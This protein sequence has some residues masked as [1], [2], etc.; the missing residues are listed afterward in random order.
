MIGRLTLRTPKVVT[1]SPELFIIM[2]NDN[3][4]WCIIIIEGLT[5]LENLQKLVIPAVIPLLVRIFLGQHFSF[6]ERQVLGR[7]QRFSDYIAS[8]EVWSNSNNNSDPKREE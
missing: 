2:I 3:L 1:R 6:Y 5:T 8:H 4:Q 7:L